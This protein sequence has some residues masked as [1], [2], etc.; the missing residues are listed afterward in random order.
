[1]EKKYSPKD[2]ELPKGA[3]RK[4]KGI[5]FDVYQWPQRM[6]DGSEKTFECI[7]RKATLNVIPVVGDKILIQEQQQPHQEQVYLSLPGGQIE[8]GEDPLEGAQREFLEE[9]GY[10]SQDWELWNL[11]RGHII[12]Q[13]KSY[14][15]VARNCK[16]IQEPQLDAGEKIKDKLITYDEFL[17]LAVHDQFRDHICKYLLAQVI[18]KSKGREKFKQLLFN[19]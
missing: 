7:T 5:L 12:I 4:F 13:W 11:W 3:Q 9:S 17:D 8:P 1:M 14:F 16:K 15:Y 6:Y 2:I 18:L 10:I 19:K